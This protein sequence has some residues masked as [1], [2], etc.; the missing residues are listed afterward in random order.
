MTSRVFQEFLNMSENEKDFVP[1]TIPNGGPIPTKKIVGEPVAV[2][3]DFNAYTIPG[4]TRVPT[5]EQANK[6]IDK[7][8]GKP[9]ERVL[10]FPEH[11]LTPFVNLF[12]AERGFIS[13]PTTIK[14]ILGVVLDSDNLLY[15]DRDKAEED[16]KFKQV[17]PYMVL[18]HRLAV[19][20]GVQYFAYQRTKKG[21]E[22]RLHDKWSIGV[23]GHI[24]PEDGETNDNIFYWVSAARELHEEV[25]LLLK[26]GTSFRNPVGLLYDP[27]DKVG[28]VHFGVVHII[29]AKPTAM[30]FHDEALARGEFK[31]PAELWDD[32]DKFENWSRLI[33]ESDV[34]K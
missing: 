27:S 1:L 21:G 34:L 4:V 5:T 15:M 29:P 6:A 3:L 16:P 32:P 18:R 8:R 33:I 7:L 13:D 25:G 22:A 9:P 24:N 30:V 12:K 19:K 17:I 11:V 2:P 10:V 28:K 23:G 14:A 31:Y 20:Q 26:D